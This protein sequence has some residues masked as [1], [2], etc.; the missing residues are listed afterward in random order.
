[1][2]RN[3]FPSITSYALPDIRA[4]CLTPPNASRVYFNGSSR[5]RLQFRYLGTHSL[6]SYPNGG[7]EVTRLSKT[8]IHASEKRNTAL[9]DASR[10]SCVTAVRPSEGISPH[11]SVQS[12]TA[13]QPVFQASCR[14]SRHITSL[15]FKLYI[16]QRNLVAGSRLCSGVQGRSPKLVWRSKLP[17]GTVDLLMSLSTPQRKM[18]ST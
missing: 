17:H 18:G 16:S 8:C 3:K 13:V 10:M 11:Q 9:N 12:C 7:T 5:S 15:H 2:N 4:P 6:S 1:M 14:S